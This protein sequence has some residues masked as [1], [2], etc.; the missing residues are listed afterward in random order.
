MRWCVILALL[1][2]VTLM[3]QVTNNDIRD[4]SILV[5]DAD[6]VISNTANNTVEWACLNKKL[7]QKCL[8]Y[9]NDQWF[10][11]HV[12]KNGDYFINIASRECRDGM[13]VQLII[14]EGNPCEVNTY[15]IMECI[16]R[17]D[18]GEVYVDLKGLKANTSYLVNVDGFLGDFCEFRIQLSTTPW[19]SPNSSDVQEVL[20]KLKTKPIEL[21]WELKDEDQRKVNGFNVYRKREGSHEK[22]LIREMNVSFNALGVMAT[23]YMMPD[24]LPA[25][26]SYTFEVLGQF[27]DASPPMLLAE[28]QVT[29][30]GKNLRFSPPLPPKT[31][32]VFPLAGRTGA[33]IELVLFNVENSDRLWTRKVTYDPNKH[34]TMELDLAPWLKRGAKRFLVLVIDEQEREPVEYYFT[35]DRDGNVVRE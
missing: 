18:Q 10:S 25:P 8:V 24:T 31:I 12:E 5:L 32:A 33:S 22:E 14:I 28:H 11:F 3:S 20:A 7:T 35:T 15:R 16:R 19:K 17:I 30:D 29:W 6:P 1:W 2:P 34:A 9:H 26:G 13:G 23:R 4:R 21:S 27:A